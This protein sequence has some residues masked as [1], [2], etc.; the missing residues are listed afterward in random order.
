MFG[1]GCMFFCKPS[2]KHQHFTK[3]TICSF[4]FS[5]TSMPQSCTSTGCMWLISLNQLWMTLTSRSLEHAWLYHGFV[6][7]KSLMISLKKNSLAAWVLFRSPFTVFQFGCLWLFRENLPKGNA[8]LRGL[9]CLNMDAAPPR[10]LSFFWNEKFM[11]SSSFN[12]SKINISLHFR[13]ENAF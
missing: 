9:S 8:I 3:I 4:E 1:S 10:K 11:F 2:Y 13:F 5:C 7:L 12:G 6:V